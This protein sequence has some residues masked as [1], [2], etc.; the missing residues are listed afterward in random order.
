MNGFDKYGKWVGVEESKGGLDG[1][2]DEDTV[3]IDS[4]PSA[5]R[6][7]LPAPTNGA[8]AG[9]S[10]DVVDDDV[11]H[12]HALKLAKSTSRRGY[13]EGDEVASGRESM[14][15]PPPPPVVV[16]DVDLKA[17]ELVLDDATLSRVVLM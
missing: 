11:D 1:Y 15:A 3:V 16:R 17:A 7:E 10:D 9:S 4:L 6:D 5:R 13:D 14:P 12:W 8:S 2:V